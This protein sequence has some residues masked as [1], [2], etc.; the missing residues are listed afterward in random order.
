VKN[1][2]ERRNATM[3]AEL[4]EEKSKAEIRTLQAAQ[5][6]AIA[7]VTTD[8]VQQY[9]NSTTTTIAK[10]FLD[11]SERTVKRVR[12]QRD[13]CDYDGTEDNPFSVPSDDPAA[14]LDDE[15]DNKEEFTSIE[16]NAVYLTLEDSASENLESEEKEPIIYPAKESSNDIWKLPSGRSARDVIRTPPKNAHRYHPSRFGI[17]RLGVG[18]RRPE[19]VEREDWLYFQHSL[20]LPRGII[21][22]DC[23]KLV[24]LLAEA[25]SPDILERCLLKE[26][27]LDELNPQKK[28]LS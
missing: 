10:R 27:T 11:V 15:L 12:T 26:R 17:I 24:L 9:A 6:V 21:M 5:H 20:P 13:S 2:W 18:V 8:Q 4:A 1:F 19:S 3:Q 28:I 16:S 25:E 7:S 23:E 14:S 22:E